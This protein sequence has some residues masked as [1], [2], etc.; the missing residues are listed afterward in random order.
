MSFLVSSRRSP[1]SVTWSL[2]LVYAGV[3][4]HIADLAYGHGLCLH[5]N[6]R[7]RAGI[8]AFVSLFLFLTSTRYRISLRLFRH[9]W[10]ARGR[11]EE[12]LKSN[13]TAVSSL[14]RTI[15]SS[16]TCA[17]SAVRC[18]VLYYLLLLCLCGP[19]F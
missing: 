18:I 6:Y 2:V 5:K 19:A 17:E 16:A 11:R 12:V 8:A 10:L 14:A 9:T 3:V 4:R 15:S 13:D 7:M 1:I